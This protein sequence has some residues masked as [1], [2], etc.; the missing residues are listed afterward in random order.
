MIEIIP[1]I[2]LI[3]GKCVRLSQGDFSRKTIYSEVP[4]DVAKSFEDAGITRLHIVDLD[5]AKNGKIINQHVLENIATNTNLIIDM[6]GGV[7]TEEDVE[8]LLNAGAKYVSVGSIA[9]K[10]PELFR[11]W[12]ND[13]GADAF[14]LGADVKNKMISVHGWLE[15]TSLSVFDFIATNTALGI[16]NIFCTDIAT[17]GMLT[18]PATELYKEILQQFP[19][20]NLIASGGVSNMHDIETLDKIGCAAV[21]VGKAI[22][23]ER[24]TLKEISAFISA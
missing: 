19:S 23:E 10:N 16:N 21:I 3:D 18:G 20:I 5:G 6:G 2:D 24:I 4:L 9:Y 22:Y 15:N 11:Q 13:F 12:V 17:D 8:L 7:R 1:A 14:L